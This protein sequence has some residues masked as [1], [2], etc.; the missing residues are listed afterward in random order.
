MMDSEQHYSDGFVDGQEM[1]I[2]EIQEIID[3]WYTSHPDDIRL[4]MDMI[5]SFVENKKREIE[6]L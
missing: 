1:M 2:D 4:A 5:K 3:T 6:S